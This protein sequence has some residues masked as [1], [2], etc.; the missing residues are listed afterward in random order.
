DDAESVARVL[1]DEL[2]ALFR[3]DFAALALI[4]EDA[5]EATGLL[6]RTGDG[7]DAEW[8][9]SVRVDLEHEPSGIASAAFEA[10]PLAVFDVEGS[11]R[12]S[13]RLAERVGAKSAAYVPMMEKE[14]VIAVISLA[15][16]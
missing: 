4:S 3:L 5:S 7:G 9:R 6:A 12:I 15:T 14:R 13:R 10:A 2:I 11:G 16:T 8:W 1:L